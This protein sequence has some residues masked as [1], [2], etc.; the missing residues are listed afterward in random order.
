MWPQWCIHH[1]ADVNPISLIV[2]YCV[3]VK[4]GTKKYQHTANTEQQYLQQFFLLLFHKGQICGGD[5]A[6]R[7]V[8]TLSPSAVDLLK[9]CRERHTSLNPV[10]MWRDVIINA[11]PVNVVFYQVNIIARLPADGAVVFLLLISFRVQ[12][13]VKQSSITWHVSWSNML[14]HNDHF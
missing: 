10:N 6:S 1:N 7:P 5:A 9:T 12:K 13:S 2:Y 11:H 14:E 3:Y 8:D 4:S